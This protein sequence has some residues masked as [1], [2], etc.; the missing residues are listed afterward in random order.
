MLGGVHV[1]EG[2]VAAHIASAQFRGESG[3]ASLMSATMAWQVDCSVHAGLHAFFRMSK[4]ISPVCGQVQTACQHVRASGLPLHQ[5]FS[6]VA[7]RCSL[8]NGSTCALSVQSPVILLLVIWGYLPIK[9]Y[10]FML[11]LPSGKWCCHKQTNR[12]PQYRLMA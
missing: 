8:E 6:L 2:V 9:N 12:L 3:A 4:Q 1:G 7:C 5:P 10:R 11:Q